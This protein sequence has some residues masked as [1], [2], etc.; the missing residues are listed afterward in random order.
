MILCAPLSRIWKSNDLNIH[1]L[2]RGSTCNFADGGGHGFL[3]L[4]EDYQSKPPI[5]C[6]L[7]R[8]C[9][10]LVKIYFTTYT[11]WSLGRNGTFAQK[12]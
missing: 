1:D 4:C 12:R 8:C 5:C 9:K 7:P 10:Q 2:N 11:S 6:K 3:P